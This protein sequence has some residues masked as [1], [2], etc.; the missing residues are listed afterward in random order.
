MAPTTPA[1]WRMI[2]ELPI[3]SSS[4]SSSAASAMVSKTD[5]ASPTCTRTDVA[6]GVPTS[7]AMTSASS[8]S[9]SRSPSAMAWTTAARSAMG[10]WD[11]ASKDRRAARMA[12]SASTASPEGTVPMISSVAASS[13]V[14]TPVPAGVTHSPSM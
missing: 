9:R 1:A 4:G 2:R 14:M 12:R 5:A 10:V 3:R 8:S 11:H 6:S 7:R 13:T